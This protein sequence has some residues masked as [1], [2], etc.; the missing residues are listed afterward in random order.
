MDVNTVAYNSQ[1]TWFMN[2]WFKGV[3]S[4]DDRI[5]PDCHTQELDQ[6]TPEQM[7]I[8][9]NNISIVG[10]HGGSRKRSRRGRSGSWWAGAGWWPGVRL[11][12]PWKVG[13][14]RP[15]AEW[16]ID[17]EDM[18]VLEGQ[19]TLKERGVKHGSEDEIDILEEYRVESEG[20]MEC[21]I[22]YEQQELLNTKLRIAMNSDKDIE[23]LSDC[24]AQEYP[25][26]GKDDEES[27]SHQT[28]HHH[29]VA[30]GANEEVQMEVDPEI[31]R[32][33]AITAAA[34]YSSSQDQPG[35]FSKFQMITSFWKEQC[36]EETQDQPAEQVAAGGDPAE[37]KAEEPVANQGNHIG[38]VHGG[39]EAIG[40]EL[41]VDHGHHHHG[42]EV[43]DGFKEIFRKVVR[44]RRR[45]VLDG[46]IQ[47]LITN[48]VTMGNVG[49]GGATLNAQTGEK[50]KALD[51]APCQRKVKTRL[52]TS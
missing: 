28:H 10:V 13:R 36:G 33:K 51:L 22:K 1:G 20:A 7:F 2:N 41:D 34:G 14:R 43:G 17:S 9:L 39:Q 26:V 19:S 35:K 23:Y 38:G 42:A 47:K 45:K 37:L 8:D 50:R 24:W 30:V 32:D 5:Q 46:K 44:A 18:V 21:G 3:V 11:G 29:G 40:Q 27:C 12:T 25:F 31:G 52:E 48:F 16:P 4:E 6:M 15:P 49:E